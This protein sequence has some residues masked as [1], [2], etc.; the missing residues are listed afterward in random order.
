MAITRRAVPAR[1]RRRHRRDHA[2]RRVKMRHERHALGSAT[3]PV[4]RLPA[5]SPGR[6][7]HRHQQRFVSHDDVRTVA[8]LIG[9]RDL[10]PSAAT[11]YLGRSRFV[12]RRRKRSTRSRRHGVFGIRQ[13]RRRSRHA[14]GARPERRAGAEGRADAVTIRNE[15]RSRRHPVLD[16]AP[17]RHRHAHPRLGADDDPAAR[18]AR[19][20]EAA[21]LNVPLV[22]PPRAGGQIVLPLVAR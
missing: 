19:L 20:I 10:K 11:T 8:S 6:P 1:A 18:S 14:G 5:R 2:A 3:V 4:A 16:Q 15:T 21:A 22:L 7:D 13:P 9:R 12:I 17:G